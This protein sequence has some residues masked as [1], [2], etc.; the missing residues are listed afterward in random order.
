MIETAAPPK[1]TRNEG[2]KQ[3]SPLLAG[4]IASTLADAAAERF[5]DD[6]Y[7]FLKFHGIYQ[8]DDRDKR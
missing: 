7:E 1:L 3:N 8:Q 2:L 4:G 6:D 5:T